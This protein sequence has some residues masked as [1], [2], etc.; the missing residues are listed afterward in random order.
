M[1]DHRDDDGG[2]AF[3]LAPIPAAAAAYVVVMGVAAT[4]MLMNADSLIITAIGPIY[5]SAM[6]MMV[7]SNGRAFIQ[8]KCLDLALEEREETVSLLLR[9]YE[10]SD[11]DW[12]W[13]TNGQIVLPQRLGPLRPGDRPPMDELE[14]QSIIDFIKQIPRAD[15][16]A[17]QA[18]RGAGDGRPARRR[19][20]SSSIRFPVGDEV[21]NDR[22]FGAPDLQ[23]AGAL[24][25]L[26]R[27]RLGRDRGPA[28]GRPHRP[29]GPPRRADRPSQP[30]PADGQS[31]RRA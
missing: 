11:A 18:R 25:R 26:S 13:Q 30:P 23:Q 15:Q 24:H 10:S 3:I 2:A 31:R 29:Y 21:K 19:S 6:L 28:G 27:R 17:A 4:R 12:L 5:T 20:A 7:V 22:A 9:E 1:R 14:G 16:G 8:R